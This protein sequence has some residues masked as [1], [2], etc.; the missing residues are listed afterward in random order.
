MSA[1]LDRTLA[2]GVCESICATTPRSGNRH[3]QPRITRAGIFGWAVVAA[4]ALITLAM[5]SGIRS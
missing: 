5:A 4:L 3:H 2:E 1:N